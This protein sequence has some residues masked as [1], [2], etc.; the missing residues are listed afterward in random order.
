MHARCAEKKGASQ[1][2]LRLTQS[3]PAPSAAHRQTIL[4]LEFLSFPN[5]AVLESTLRYGAVICKGGAVLGHGAIIATEDVPAG[6][7]MPTVK[8][9]VVAVAPGD[10]RHLA[11]GEGA[12][13]KER[14][15]SIITPA[16]KGSRPR[17]FLGPARFVNHDCAPNVKVRAIWPCPLDMCAAILAM[18]T[19]G[20][21]P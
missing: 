14:D 10:D 7:L 13:G 15:F 5:Q 18:A 21:A 17:L 8:G 19:N 4:Y 11:K 9:T 20:D 16:S 6:V 12:A 2:H 1:P 3:P